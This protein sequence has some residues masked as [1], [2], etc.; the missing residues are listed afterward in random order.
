MTIQTLTNAPIEQILATFN[1]SFSDYLVPLQLTEEQLE[2]K[3]HSENI[4][5]AFS[6]G[7]F[8]DGELVGFILHATGIVN[9]QKVAYNAGTGVVPAHRGKNLTARLYAFILPFLNAAGV[10]S[11]VLEVITENVAALKTYQNTG[12]S[13]RRELICFKGTIEAGEMAPNHYRIESLKTHDWPLLQSFWDWSPSW[14][15]AQPAV[16]QLLDSNITL[17]SFD[18]ER[19]AGYLIFNPQSKRIQQF[20]VRQEDRR[21]HVAQSLFQYVAGHFG[22]EVTLINVD[23]VSENT[24][25]FLEE[26]GL[27]PFVRQYEMEMRVG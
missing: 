8:E 20:A 1:R 22:A 24:I 18:G 5:L 9:G 12:F 13:V 14:Q 3:I 11:V 27:K 17:A 6:A 10:Q 4:D 7:A 25:G 19:L 2:R 26:I 23:A 16:D 21:R 15:N